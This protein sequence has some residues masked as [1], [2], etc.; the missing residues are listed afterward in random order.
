MFKK[1]KLNKIILFTVNLIGFLGILL[2]VGFTHDKGDRFLEV[3]AIYILIWVYLIFFYYSE[4]RGDL[5]GKNYELLSELRK[6]DKEW[7]Q[8]VNKI[9]YFCDVKQKIKISDLDKMMEKIA[10]IN[11]E[12][13]ERINNRDYLIGDEWNNPGFK[14][15]QKVNEI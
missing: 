6:R 13:E 3:V 2:L 12:R 7:N 5:K 14:K 10:K 15:R 1:I 9:D 8:L 11:D 4:S